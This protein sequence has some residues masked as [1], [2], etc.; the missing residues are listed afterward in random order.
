M[1]SEELK[2]EWKSNENKNERSKK[3]RNKLRRNCLLKG[4]VV[5]RFRKKKL[6]KYLYMWRPK[7]SKKK[8]TIR[9]IRRN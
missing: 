6:N 8:L 3:Y 9:K 5:F 7:D 1:S 2:K 4:V